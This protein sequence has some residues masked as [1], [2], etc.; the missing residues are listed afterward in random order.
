MHLCVNPFL[1]VL[2]VHPT[3]ILVH[4]RCTVTVHTGWRALVQTYDY[5]SQ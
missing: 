1:L 3:H 4:S 2:V 5:R